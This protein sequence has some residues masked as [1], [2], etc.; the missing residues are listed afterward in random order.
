[1]PIKNASMKE[2]VNNVSNLLGC[3]FNKK[4]SELQNTYTDIT[5]E[6]LVTLFADTYLEKKQLRFIWMIW[7]GAGK[8]R[9]MM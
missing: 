1:M 4:I 2:W 7:I 8:I 5:N 9:Q 3:M 6:Q